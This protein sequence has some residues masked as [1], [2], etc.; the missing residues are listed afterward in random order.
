M[1][2]TESARVVLVTG[3][4][5]RIG[6]EIVRCL[7]ESGWR[8]IIHCNRSRSEAEVLATRLNQMRADSAQILQADFTGREAMNSMVEE[9]LSL[10]G[11]LDA[12]VN[13]ASAF[14]PTPLGEVTED[15]WDELMGANLKAPFFLA[16]AAAGS[17]AQRSGAIVNLVD[18]YAERPLKSYPVYSIAKAGLA[19]LT[20]SLA[21]EMAPHIRVNGVSPGAIL[22]PEHGGDDA[23]A[24]L[25]ARVPLGR[26]GEPRDIAQA[27][28]F[29]LEGAPYVTGQI[30]A[31][32]GGRS[33]FI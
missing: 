1:S 9:S 31:V 21:V 20:R 6:A 32:D 22:W 10:W 7:H 2:V 4:S 30:I 16:Q 12:L 8:V 19:A 25:L 3:G 15:Q 27:V 28:E 14:Y 11:R 13:N 26:C 29:F 33:I 24:E 17:L 23:Q 18:V 5:R